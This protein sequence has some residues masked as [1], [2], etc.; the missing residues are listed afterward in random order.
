MTMHKMVNGEVVECSP[1]EE[2]AI[3]AERAAHAAPRVPR[4]VTM[5]QARLALLGAGLLANVEAAID[6]LEE[7]DRSAARIEWEYSQEV[8]RH[9]PFVLVLGAAMGLD[10]AALDQLFITAEGL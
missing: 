7:P 9:R 3:L 8:H 4:A 10:S 2:A 1:E 6:A 5:R